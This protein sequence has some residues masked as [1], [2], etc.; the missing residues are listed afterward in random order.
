MRF[1][2]NGYV[3]G[4]ALIALFKLKFGQKEGFP[5]PTDLSLVRKEIIFP[6]P[7]PSNGE[8]PSLIKF[9]VVVQAGYR[10]FPYVARVLQPRLKLLLFTVCLC[11]TSR[12][13]DGIME[14]RP[15]ACNCFQ[16]ND[17]VRS[18]DCDDVMHF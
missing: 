8:T 17:F 10:S 2:E 15:E 11:R 3:T 13:F 4:G 6:P 7:S 1:K 14:Q 5:T 16:D 9:L 12:P 18:R